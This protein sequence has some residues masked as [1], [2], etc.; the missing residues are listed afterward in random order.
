MS[1]YAPRQTL[2]RR[3][4]WTEFI[5]QSLSRVSCTYVLSSLFYQ[6]TGVSLLFSKDTV[7]SKKELSVFSLRRL[8]MLTPGYSGLLR[9]TSCKT[10]EKRGSIRIKTSAGQIELA[11]KAQAYGEDWESITETVYLTETHPNYGGKRTWFLCPSCHSRRAKL[12]G[13]KYFRCRKCLDLCYET[14]LEN[15]S[16]RLMSAMYKIRHRLG[17][18][19]GL[20]EWFPDKPKGMRWKTY[21]A[22]WRRYRALDGH[23]NLA[24]A[25]RFGISI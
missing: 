14:Q 6:K 7:E 8:G 3:L 2:A 13:G 1:A 25:K 18:Y 17:D 20:D 16:S 5:L 4:N 24:W 23:L 10:G 11:Y 21:N 19:N 12:Y 9:W 22:L 15:E